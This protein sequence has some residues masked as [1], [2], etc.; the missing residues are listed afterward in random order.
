MENEIEAPKKNG[1]WELVPYHPS[2]NVLGCKC[3][4]RTKYEINGAI[5]KHKARLVAKGF[6]QTPS[7]DYNDTFSP[8]IKSSTLR[9]MFSLVVS[10]GWDIRQIDINNAFLNGDFE[11]TVYT[12][13]P[14][15]FEDRNRP[16]HVC[17]L[18]KALYGLK[19]AP[20]AQELGFKNI[21]EPLLS[22]HFKTLNQTP[23][24]S[25]TVIKKLFSC[26]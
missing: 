22:G 5:D 21:K 8:V 15:G 1:T 14:E 23:H 4:F 7:I 19:Q 24:Y 11:E 2:M 16:P 26:S 20:R 17:R 9:I 13:Q 12:S 10:Y 6:H 3:V 25:S 18:I